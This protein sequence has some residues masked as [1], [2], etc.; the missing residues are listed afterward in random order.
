MVSSG[1]S[2]GGQVTMGAVLLCVQ[3]L[4]M[5]MVSLCASEIVLRVLK[6]SS[7]KVCGIIKNIIILFSFLAGTV[8]SSARQFLGCG[9]NLGSR[10]GISR[11]FGVSVLAR[12][13]VFLLMLFLSRAV[14][15]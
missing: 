13:A 6:T 11:V 4:F 1:A 3:V 10:E 5:V 15:L 12:L 7:F 9:L 14:K 2:G 8:A